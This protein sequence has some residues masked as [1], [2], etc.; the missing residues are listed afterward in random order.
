MIQKMKFIGKLIGGG[1]V[2]LL[3]LG[4]THCALLPAKHIVIDT[5]ITKD[6][7]TQFL[8]Q[9]KN[10]SFNPFERVLIVLNTPGGDGD[11]MEQML[12][13][14]HNSPEPIDTYVF[15]ESA[16]AG[17]DIFISGQH[18]YVN[19][20]SMIIF[21][22][23]YMGSYAMSQPNLENAIFQ[24]HHGRFNNNPL[25]IIVD[26]SVQEVKA[27][28]LIQFFVKR[29]GVNGCE[30]EMLTILDMLK[31]ANEVQVTAVY[32]AIHKIH[33]EYTKE[34]VITIFFGD[35]KKDMY[36]TGQDLINLGLAELYTGQ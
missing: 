10:S 24:L 7:L 31:Q 3:I 4:L 35:F 1:L 29:M 17:A 27:M 18:R 30:Q 34:Q 21:H 19:K 13:I 11:V 22:G 33:P 5:E 12:K 23:A 16:S 15:Q 8:I 36:F 32:D 20:D 14:M 26:P 2:L 6:T 28:E 25:T 9:F